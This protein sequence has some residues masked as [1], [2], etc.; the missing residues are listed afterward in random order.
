M[1]KLRIKKHDQPKFIIPMLVDES[2]IPRVGDYIKLPASGEMFKVHHV[3]W[4]YE[5]KSV[6]DIAHSVT[7]T[8]FVIY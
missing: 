3:I 6:S 2:A 5:P 7:I 1:F 4:E 8:I